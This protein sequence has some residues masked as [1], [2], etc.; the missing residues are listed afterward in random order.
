MPKYPPLLI[1][2]AVLMSIFSAQVSFA[3][4]RG[5][6]EGD[7]GDDL[8]IEFLLSFGTAL[9]ELQT[10]LPNIY[11]SLLPLQLPQMAASIKI[12]ILDCEETQNDCPINFTV[13]IDG[14]PQQSVAINIASAN[15]IIINRV[16]WNKIKA[17]H[18]KE[19]IAL[20]EILSMKKLEGSGF[21]PISGKYVMAF[22][23]P[24]HS[25][26]TGSLEGEM[27]NRDLEE[28]NER[29][30]MAL[31]DIF[32]LPS[33]KAHAYFSSNRSI[34]NIWPNDFQHRSLFFQLNKTYKKLNFGLIPTS[35]Q[36]IHFYKTTPCPFTFNDS[37]GNIV[38]EYKFSSLCIAKIIQSAKRSINP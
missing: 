2:L 32:K 37:N 6:Q 31:G 22:Q 14:I 1:I 29:V 20:H 38:T 34:E 16:R 11:E 8:S 17:E 35:E 27:D 7:A 19:A 21:Y 15:T 10:S 25:M 12:V 3:S 18:I 24:I 36:L 33:N 13:T 30:V 9:K 23:L 4:T 28:E 26:I 5:G